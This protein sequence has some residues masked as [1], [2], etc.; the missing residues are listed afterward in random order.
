MEILNFNE[1]L[2]E[3]YALNN[4]ICSHSEDISSKNAIHLEY[5][6]KT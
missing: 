2:S 1:G 5:F 4:E 3:M 6:T